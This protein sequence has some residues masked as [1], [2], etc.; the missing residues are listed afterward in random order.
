LNF[1]I[2]IQLSADLGTFTKFQKVSANFVWSITRHNFP[3]VLIEYTLQF[4]Q[5]TLKCDVSIIGYQFFC[6]T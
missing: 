5:F 6:N 3:V 4:F 2:R 1:V